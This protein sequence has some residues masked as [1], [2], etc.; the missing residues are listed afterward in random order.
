MQGGATFGWLVESAYRRGILL[1][2]SRA[3]SR[4]LSAPGSSKVSLRLMPSSIGGLVR[5]V[6]TR[7]ALPLLDDAR[8]ETST[9]PRLR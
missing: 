6:T 1:R 3:S 7:V 9:T 5:S 4:M 8:T 2:Q